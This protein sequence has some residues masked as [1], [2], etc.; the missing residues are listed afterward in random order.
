[1]GE[2]VRKLPWDHELDAEESTTTFLQRWVLRPNGHLE[3]EEIPV[4]RELF[5]DPPLEGKILQGEGH[6]DTVRELQSLIHEHFRFKKKSALV[7]YDVKHFFGI[8]GFAPAPDVSVIFG[9][10][11]RRDYLEKPGSFDVDKEGVRPSLVVEVVSP[12]DPRL[13]ETDRVD[14]V[15]DYRRAGIP[16]YILVEPPQPETNSRF[17]VLG[18]RLDSRRRYLPIKKDEQGRILSEATGLL[19]AVSPDGDRVLVFDAETGEELLPGSVEKEGRIAAE[20]R[21]ERETARAEREA[22]K[23]QRETA[24]AEQATQAR[25]TA[26]EQA[27]REAAARKAE[28]DA[29]KTAEAELARIR[30]ELERLKSSN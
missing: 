7:L 23:A 9:F 20:E 3:M 24:R 17:E 12:R 19:F 29:R 28:E 26:E 6:N 5:L 14:K 15:R 13:Q 16:E 27:K 30:E 22:A 10:R 4:T 8:P 11:P 25:I 18:Y 21:A 1:M 2:P